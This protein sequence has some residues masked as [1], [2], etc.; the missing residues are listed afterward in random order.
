MKFRIIIVL[1]VI[2]AIIS[3]C[4]SKTQSVLKEKQNKES[5]GAIKKAPS[6]VVDFYN[7]PAQLPTTNLG[8]IIYSQALSGL[9][10][11]LNGWRV[12]YVTSTIEGT[13]TFASASIYAPRDNK[14]HNLVVWAHGSLGIAD[15]CAPSRSQDGAEKIA[16]FNDYINKGYAVIAPDYEGFGTPGT[17]PFLVGESEGRSVLDSIRMAQKFDPIKPIPGAVIV[18][19]SQGGQSALFAGELRAKYAPDVSLAGV[20]AIAPAGDLTTLFQSSSTS[21]YNI[22]FIVMAAVGFKAEYDELDLSQVLTATAIE[23]SSIVERGCLFSVLDAFKEDIGTTFTGNPA[24]ISSWSKRL[25]ENSPGNT[26]IDSPT[27][28]LHGLDDTT[29]P[30]IVSQNIFAATCKLGTLASRE[31]FEGDNHNSILDTSKSNVMTF[32]KDRFDKKTFAGSCS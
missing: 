14:K 5:P 24:E 13:P 28:L 18:G 12:L 21:G 17:H 11:K 1:I 16:N 30:S 23:K 20:V 10:S 19:H 3:G 25:N 6:S 15:E 8:D 27:L 9:S 7:G 22:G 4:S 2:L 32:I 26:L 31:T 29:V